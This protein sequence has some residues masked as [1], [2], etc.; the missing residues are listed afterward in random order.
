MRASTVAKCDAV[1]RRRHRH[2]LALLIS[3]FHREK[4]RISEST[5]TDAHS[6]SP[7]MT[8]A[9]ERASS[10]LGKAQNTTIRSLSD[11]LIIGVYAT[12][13]RRGRRSL[14]REGGYHAAYVRDPAAHHLSPAAGAC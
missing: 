7:T 6:P 8:V 4:V 1:V 5:L 9:T 12:P 14:P 11:W 3:P 10:S 2:S 13:P